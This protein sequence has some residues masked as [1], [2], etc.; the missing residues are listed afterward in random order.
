MVSLVRPFPTCG[1]SI[2]GDWQI[3]EAKGK[4]SALI[5]EAQTAPQTITRHG[6][7]VAVIVSAEEYDRLTNRPKKSLL[8]FL[9]SAPLGELDLERDRSD[10]GRDVDL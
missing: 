1:V 2:V 10:F 7:P 3:Q 4:F 9:Q 8:E 5:N 6:E